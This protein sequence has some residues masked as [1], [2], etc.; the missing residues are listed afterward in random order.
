MIIK[1]V[2]QQELFPLEHYFLH[3]FLY[4]DYEKF[5]FLM[6]Y[7]MGFS[8]YNYSVFVPLRNLIYSKDTRIFSMLPSRSFIV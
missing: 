4:I 7:N 2:K 5:S 3:S 1:I 8:L 6:K